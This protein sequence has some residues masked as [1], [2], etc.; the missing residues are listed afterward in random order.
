MADTFDI[1]MLG[2]KELVRALDK[3]QRKDAA[4]ILRQELRKSAGRTKTRLLRNLS[5]YPVAVD[6]GTTRDAFKKARVKSA[7]ARRGDI[8]LGIEMPAR[9]DLGIS[10]TDKFYYPTA[11]EYGYDG[12]PARPFMRPAVDEHKEDEYRRIGGA[13]AAKITALWRRIG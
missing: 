12:V 9:A 10:P 1:S 6:T 3:L 11:I 13:I 2:D 4:R 5:G 8:R 7:R